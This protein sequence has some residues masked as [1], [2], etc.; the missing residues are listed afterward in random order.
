MKTILTIILCSRRSVV[1]PDGKFHRHRSQKQSH[2]FFICHLSRKKPDC[3]QTYLPLSK[4]DK[5]MAW[6]LWPPWDI[7]EMKYK[8]ITKDRHEQMI[9]K[10]KKMPGMLD[11]KTPSWLTAKTTSSSIRILSGKSLKIDID[12]EFWISKH[13]IAVASVAAII[14]SVYCRPTSSTITRKNCKKEDYLTGWPWPAGPRVQLRCCLCFFLIE[15]L[16]TFI[17][18]FCFFLL[19]K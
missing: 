9:S 14:S 17:P 2:G 11:T 1:Y 10:C 5:F 8:Q 12:Y 16:V 13:K 6:R 15:N 7:L 4:M 3:S 19:R 18:L